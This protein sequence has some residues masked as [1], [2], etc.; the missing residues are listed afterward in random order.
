M[1]ARGHFEIEE[2]ANC[3]G[4]FPIFHLP[5]KGPIKFK[6]LNGYN[7][8]LFSIFPKDLDGQIGFR[9]GKL[10]SEAVQYARERDKSFQANVCFSG[11]C[12]NRG[13]VNG[14]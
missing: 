7:I 5:L 6:S 13:R 9:L 10:D 4:S 1:G 11:G 14:F 12:L 2:G 3:L 8:I